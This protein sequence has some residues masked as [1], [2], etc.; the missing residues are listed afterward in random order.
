MKYKR[1]TLLSGHYGSG[2][3]GIAVA[4]A[5]ELKKRYDRVAIADLDIVNPYF[6]TKDSQDELEAA[7]IRLICSK[8]ANS[9]VDLPALPDEM[10]SVID[11]PDQHVIIDVGGD[12]RGALALGRLVPALLEEDDF[13]MYMVINMYRPLTGTPED[14]FEILKEIERACG[15]RFT[16][17][18]NNSNLGNLTQA[19]DVLAS[20]E[21]AGKVAEL[22]GLPL[23]ATTVEEELYGELKDRVEE[24]YPIGI[25][26]KIFE[27]YKEG[28]NQWQG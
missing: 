15:M 8:Y 12:D 5:K 20:A 4:M 25:R 9:N 7:G 21:Y 24:L 23:A 16:G 10:Y 6:R 28:S 19:G 22:T 3:T 14:T 18:I 13:D 26:K 1:V 11:E 27:Y 17:L 2:K